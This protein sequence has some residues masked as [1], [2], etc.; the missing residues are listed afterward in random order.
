VPYRDR[1]TVRA[2]E[3]ETVVREIAA[4]TSPKNATRAAL[5]A[6]ALVGVVCAGPAGAQVLP[7]Y[8]VAS[9]TLLA[10]GLAHVTLVRPGHV[11]DVAHEA[12]IPSGA[13]VALRVAT[14]ADGAGGKMGIVAPT[15]AMCARAACLLAVNGPMI[16]R[17]THR[18]IGGL[19]QDGEMI[20]SPVAS[21]HDVVSELMILS[22]GTLAF[23]DMRWSGSLVLPGQKIAI[24]GVNVS[25]GPSD[26][27]LYTP[28]FGSSTETDASGYEVVFRA[29][30]QPKLDRTVDVELLKPGADQGNTPIP[31][32]GGV[33]SAHGAAADALRAMWQRVSSGGSPPGGWIRMASTL[34]VV[35]SMGGRPVL[36]RDGARAPMTPK[37]IARID[38][39]NPR[40]MVG[41]TASGDV[42]LV[43]VDGRQ[44]GYSDGMTLPEA[45]D[46]MIHLGAVDAINLDGGGSTT[47]VVG[48]AV[49]NRPSDRLVDHLGHKAIVKLLGAH[50]KQIK[51]NIERPVSAA[52]VVVAAAAAVKPATPSSPAPRTSAARTAQAPAGAPASGSSAPVALGTP[53][54]PERAA[55]GWIIGIAAWLLAAAWYG[56]VRYLS[57]A[58][59]RALFA[60]EGGARALAASLAARRARARR[61]L[62]PRA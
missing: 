23:G 36:V 47:F 25:R 49:A 31:A 13:P 34:G 39:S 17:L 24:T 21:Q 53:H 28:R 51:P 61:G 32:N 30:Q 48:G 60:G 33:L 44:A 16:E 40:T 29:A 2:F 37:E 50:D 35:Q 3:E 12:I 56:R 62:R 11:R 46:L 6:L 10:G 7:A 20:R 57:R 54:D 4:M 59:T 8:Q 26:L 18:S 5:A 43:T 58:A 42:L 15:S 55:R 1:S 27:V 22:N 52:L 38:E 14:A 9:T 19:V 41:R 45:A